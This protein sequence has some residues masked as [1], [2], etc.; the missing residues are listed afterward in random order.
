M[1]P[2]WIART[3]RRGQLAA[4]AT[5]KPP[6]KALF[7]RQRAVLAGDRG[8]IAVLLLLPL[9]AHGPELAAFV[10][11][12]PLYFVSGLTPNVL[13]GV[14]RGSPGWNDPNAGFTT[15]ALGSEAARQWLHGQVPWWN[16]F[17]GVGLPLAA[18]MQNSALF[19]PF[20]LLLKLFDGVLFLKI[21]MQILAGLAAFALLRALGMI[22][23]IA[24]L[25]GGLYA[26][27]GSFAWMSHAPIMPVP[28]LP[29]LLLGIERARIR[30]PGGGAGWLTCIAFATA[31]S[32]YAGFPE[33]AFIDGIFAVAWACVRLRQH[34]PAMRIRFV[35]KLAAGAALGLMLA[36]PAVVPFLAVLPDCYVGQHGSAVLGIDK[37]N[38][39]MFLFPTLLG[40]LGYDW[41][42]VPWATAGG[43]VSLALAFVASQALTQ[44]RREFG[45]RVLLA[46]WILVCLAQSGGIPQLARLAGHVPVL[47]DIWFGR[48]APPSWELACIV[49]VAFALDDW[50]CGAARHP[51][52]VYTGLMCMGVAASGVVALAWPTMRIVLRDE[53]DYPY[54]ATASILLGIAVSCACARLL[55]LQPA[56]RNSFALCGLLGLEAFCFSMV[57]LLADTPTHTYDK[58]A[59]DYL[60]KNI[61]LQRF[62]TLGPFAPNYGAMFDIASIN[63]NYLPTPRIWVDYIRKHLYAASDDVSFTGHPTAPGAA[64]PQAALRKNAAAY[65]AIGVKYVL[66]PP[67]DNPFA[68]NGRPASGRPLP[69]YRG[70]SMDI[71]ALDSVAP[72]FEP[73][74]GPCMV[75]AASRFDLRTDCQSA[76]TVIRREMYFPGWRATL[77]GRSTAISMAE[78]LFQAVPVPAGRAVLHFSYA[79]PFTAW[80]Y[81]SLALGL[82]LLA[83]DAARGRF[84]SAMGWS[85]SRT[86]SSAT[87]SA[88]RM[89]STPAERMPPA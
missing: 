11:P 79:P 53:P 7:G 43:Y 69:V 12:N 16:A 27:N 14:V 55:T 36:A 24:L 62:Y 76:A 34:A 70:Q 15:Q 40:P 65:A 49:L 85:G 75:D 50:H 73:V 68:D 72:Y 86:R 88:T 31:Y 81:A 78:G 60:R 57:P 45:L 77:D 59:V 10:S 58:L 44:R 17:S 51:R 26:L 64:T 48:Y 23:R 37:A 67:G 52:A 3:D 22:R 38:Y 46:G 21:A 8:A 89:P 42:F 4:H 13:S 61:G 84:Y 5:T 6:D 35:C 71:Y 29:L 30:T 54:F 56:M 1:T 18:E 63:H 87:A 41:R 2:A 82:G 25:G 20:V 28:F 19:L 33:T 47:R 66:V 83:A 39:A 74:G 80:A 32:L 9:L